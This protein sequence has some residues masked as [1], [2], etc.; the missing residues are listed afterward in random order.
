[1]RTSQQN[2]LKTLRVLLEKETDAVM[3]RLQAK[4]RED[5]KALSKDNKN[6]DEITR[7][8]NENRKWTEF[9]NLTI[10]SI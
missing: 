5:V 9:L 3:R 4:R 8:V 1:M 10:H 6:K 2:Q 7:F